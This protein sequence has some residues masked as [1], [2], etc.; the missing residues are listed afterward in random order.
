ISDYKDLRSIGHFYL[1]EPDKWRM[2]DQGADYV[3]TGRK[4]IPF[5]LPN[6]L[7]E[8]RDYSTWLLTEDLNKL[9]LFTKAEYAST[10]KRHPEINFIRFSIDELDEEFIA[11]LK[12][13]STS[14]AVIE[15]TNTHAM[16]ELRR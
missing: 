2:N 9:P 6:G 8:I 4:P 11:K 5:M 13:D 12:S 1:P 15:T 7:K 3:Y 14:V 16:P 10:E